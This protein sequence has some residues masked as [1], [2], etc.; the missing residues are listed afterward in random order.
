MKIT[1]NKYGNMIILFENDK[2][3]IT[4]G[5]HCILFTLFIDFLFVIAIVA[6]IVLNCFTLKQIFNKPDREVW[7]VFSTIGAII[8]IFSYINIAI[9]N[10]GIIT[11]DDIERLNESEIKK[12]KRYKIIK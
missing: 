11:K 3:L 7:G 1:N 5:P 10:P 6:L 2:W 12:L 9:S 4:L 8:Q